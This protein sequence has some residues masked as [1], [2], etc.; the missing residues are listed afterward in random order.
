MKDA[1]A[2]PT[3][4]ILSKFSLV[5]HTVPVIMTGSFRLIFGKLGEIN[6]VL[7]EF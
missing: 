1:I 5:G 6:R 7:I 2:P 4:G 3:I